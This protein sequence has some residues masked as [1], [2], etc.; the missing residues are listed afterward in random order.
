MPKKSQARGQE[1][2]AASPTTPPAAGA[3]R[4]RVQAALGG[5]ILAVVLGAG[6]WLRSRTDTPPPASA[7]AAEKRYTRGTAGAPVVITEFSD[8]T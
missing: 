3:S 7:P 6:V 8:Y 4:W 5:V 1:G 2:R